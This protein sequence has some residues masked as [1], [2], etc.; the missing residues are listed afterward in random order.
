MTDRH[1][2]PP[3][4]AISH[5]PWKEGCR[6]GLPIIDGQP[7]VQLTLLNE[8]VDLIAEVAPAEEAAAVLH[9]LCAYALTRFSLHDGLENHQLEH[10]AFI[11]RVLGFNQRCAPEDPAFLE[12]IHVFLRDGYA[13]PILEVDLRCVSARRQAGMVT[14]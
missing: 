8:V 11:S 6:T 12:A 7:R 4:A 1:G 10:A 2:T 5:I 9:R 14:A 3:E 13:H